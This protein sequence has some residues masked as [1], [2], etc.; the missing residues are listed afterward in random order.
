MTHHTD[1]AGTARRAAR[2]ARTPL[3]PAVLGLEEATVLDGAASL[4]EAVSG[5]V[6]RDDRVRG[7][8]QGDWL[9]HALHPLLV[10]VPLGT[11]L[12]AALLD[13]TGEESADAARLLVGAGVLAAVPAVAAG[14]A[15]YA[16]CGP[17]ERRVAV[18]HAAA[19]G[20]GMVLQTASW[21]SRRAGRHGL[22]KVLSLAAMT[23]A[24]SAGYLG[25]HLTTVRKVG[26]SDP[27]YEAAATA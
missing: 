18:V 8:L 14:W 27:A 7:L 15:E 22:G 6:T 3:V 25:G 11:W 19:N 20:V 10:Q 13:A 4:G 2:Q 21:M 24:G 26:S 5:A 12:S 9:G 16:H 17:R 1:R 23:A